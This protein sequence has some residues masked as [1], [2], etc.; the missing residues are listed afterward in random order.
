MNNTKVD[1]KMNR[2]QK[3]WV[4][5]FALMTMILG[6]SYFIWAVL[7]QNKCFGKYSG[8][9]ECQGTSQLI[10]LVFFVLILIFSILAMFNFIKK[11][12]QGSSDKNND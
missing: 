6:S 7:I 11:Q 4:G 9:Y 2:H 1:M 12:I 10:D 5:F 8:A 3:R